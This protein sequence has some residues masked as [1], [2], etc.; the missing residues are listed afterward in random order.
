MTLVISCAAAVAVTVIWYLN[1][2][3]QLMLGTLA[4]MLWGAS[5]MWLVDAAGAFLEEGA[6]CF[7][8]SA[9]KML[10]DAFLGICVTLLA[11][12]IWLVILLVKDPEGRIRRHLVKK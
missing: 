10:N 4:L 7:V 11:F 12:V 3:R 8:Q 9:D 5:L 2:K 1:E 6:A